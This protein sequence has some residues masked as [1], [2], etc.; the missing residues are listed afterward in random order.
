MII[1][2]SGVFVITTILVEGYNIATRAGFGVLAL[3]VLMDV[4]MVA[5]QERYG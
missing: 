3:C 5:E 2:E 4:V 1:P